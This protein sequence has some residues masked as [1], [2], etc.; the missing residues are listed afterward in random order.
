MSLPDSA[1]P[2][3]T[4]DVRSR[5]S[6]RR[7]GALALLG[8]AAAA[9]LLPIPPLSA[10]LFCVSAA[11]VV[12]SGLWW[13]GWLGGADRLTAVSWL[14]DGSW[15]LATATRTNIPAT[16]SADSRIGSRWVWLRWHTPGSR[17]RSRSM[18]ILKGD[19]LPAELRR[20]N[21]RLRLES[22]SLCALAGA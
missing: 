3:L 13:Q 18:L 22:V 8:V 1:I 14:S 16:L 15:L 7:L 5:R 21:A 4:L 17:P 20:L 6:E 19:V 11:A 2:T 10:A 9:M 12:G